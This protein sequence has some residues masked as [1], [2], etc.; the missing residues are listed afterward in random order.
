MTEGMEN[1]KVGARQPP[2]GESNQASY[3]E[4][5]FAWMR[6]ESILAREKIRELS[7]SQITS[8]DEGVHSVS[9]C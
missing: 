9:L 5:S 3:R 4:L 6:S 8:L 1:F 7:S 2:A